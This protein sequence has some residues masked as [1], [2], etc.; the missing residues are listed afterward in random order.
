ML[1]KYNAKK[2]VTSK[3][4]NNMGGKALIKSF[5]QNQSHFKQSFK[6][7][8]IRWNMAYYVQANVIIILTCYYIML[9]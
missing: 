7:K 9:W 4:V 2:A 3:T 1:N 5:P 8:M 6:V